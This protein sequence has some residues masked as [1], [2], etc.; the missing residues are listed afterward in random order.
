MIVVRQGRPVRIEFFR[1]ETASCSEQVVFPD[2]GVVRDLPAFRATT[3]E[4]LPEEAGEF[5][6]TCGMRML[7]GRLVVE[8][9]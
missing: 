5:P 9:A 2:F 6:F 4:L 1:D 7:R 3:V 8:P